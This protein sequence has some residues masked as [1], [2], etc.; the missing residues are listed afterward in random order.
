MSFSEDL[1]GGNNKVECLQSGMYKVAWVACEEQGKR[2]VKEIASGLNS[3]VH[4]T[5]EASPNRP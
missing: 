1:K 3:I 4:L 5:S 2:Y